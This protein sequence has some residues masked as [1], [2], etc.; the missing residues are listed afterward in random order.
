MG[1]HATPLSFTEEFYQAH[2][3][4]AIGRGRWLLEQFNQWISGDFPAF[5]LPRWAGRAAE[6]L[7]EL[8]D[9]GQ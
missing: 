3:D 4:E 6:I 1:K 7:K 2:L 8:T 5:D 9:D